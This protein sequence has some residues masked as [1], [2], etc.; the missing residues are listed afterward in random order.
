MYCVLRSSTKSFATLDHK[1]LCSRYA[2]TFKELDT[3]VEKEESCNSDTANDFR[4]DTGHKFPNNDL[5]LITALKEH[6]NSL[7]QRFRDTQFIIESLI[8]DLQYI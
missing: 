3:V 4:I 2:N 7:K 8:A 1:V 5:T 6:I